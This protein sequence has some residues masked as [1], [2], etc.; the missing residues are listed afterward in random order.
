M[1]DIASRTSRIWVDLPVA[2]EWAATGEQVE[3]DCQVAH[4]YKAVADVDAYLIVPA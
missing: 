2:M 1:I 3:D 4:D